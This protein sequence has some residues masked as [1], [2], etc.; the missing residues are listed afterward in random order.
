MKRD[1]G[2]EV[3]AQAV[4]SLGRRAP[5]PFVAVDFAAFPDSLLESELFG[6]VR[7][8]FTGA[9]RDKT[10]LFEQAG[11]G[12]LFLDEIGETSGPLQAKLLRVVQEREIRPVGGATT[13][14]VGV[15][16]VAPVSTGTSAP[17]HRGAS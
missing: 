9:D 1:F 10:E 14:K 8:A 17:K 4:H 12:T 13:R 15:R 3:V 5:L 7:G 6:H 11:G 16:I 2:N